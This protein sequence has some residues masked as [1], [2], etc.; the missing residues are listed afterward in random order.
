MSGGC[1][2]KSTPKVRPRTAWLSCDFRVECASSHFCII[3]R[4]R[5]PL[6]MVIIGVAGGLA[7][8]ASDC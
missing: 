7:V 4:G 3:N 5:H 8:K 2:V 1:V 6:V